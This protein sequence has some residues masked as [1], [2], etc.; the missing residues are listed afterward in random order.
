MPPKVSPE[1]CEKNW[2]HLTFFNTIKQDKTDLDNTEQVQ[3]R[4]DKL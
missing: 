1:N 4:S 3:T 2:V